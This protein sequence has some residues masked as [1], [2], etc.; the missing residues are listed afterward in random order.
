[1]NSDSPKN[2]QEKVE[3]SLT[4][5]LL[6]ELSH[7]QAAELHEK[8]ARDPELS[9]LY[10]RL[11]ETI[12]VVRETMHSPDEQVAEASEPLKLSEEKRQ[13]LF[14]HFKTV[15]PKEFA[16]PKRKPGMQR[17]EMAI[18]AA[19]VGLIGISGMYV[20]NQSQYSFR[21]EHGS[22]AT[23]TDMASAKYA[24]DASL[25][26]STEAS[27]ETREPRVATTP[28]SG[29]QQP[30]G[31][32]TF[33]F[34]NRTRSVTAHSGGSNVVLP[35]ANWNF[36]TGIEAKR[37]TDPT[38]GEVHGETAWQT[39]T[40][41]A[42]F[43][44]NGQVAPGLNSGGAAGN[45]A[46][47]NNLSDG[48]SNVYG[49]NVVGYYD[50]AKSAS[51]GVMI[52]N[53]LA[54]TSSNSIDTSGKSTTLGIS[55]PRGEQAPTSRAGNPEVAANAANSDAS[56]FD[57][58]S[59]AKSPDSPHDDVLRK[60]FS[61]S[62]ALPEVAQDGAVGGEGKAAPVGQAFYYTKSAGGPSS[63]WIRNF[64]VG[65][66][67]EVATT[68]AFGSLKDEQKSP[69]WVDKS[70]EP[71]AGERFYRS[72]TPAAASPVS[73]GLLTNS[74]A[75]N[76]EWAG[77]ANAPKPTQ[78]SNAFVS[79]YAYVTPPPS[80][81]VDPRTN[82]ILTALSSSTISG[83]VDTSGQW[84]PG[85]GGG[86]KTGASG[87]AEGFNYNAVTVAAAET[88]RTPL[89]GDLPAMGSLFRG[90]LGGDREKLGKEFRGEYKSPSEPSAASSTFNSGV[91]MLTNAVGAAPAGSAVAADDLSLGVPE[92]HATFDTFTPGNPPGEEAFRRRYGGPGTN[93]APYTFTKRLSMEATNTSSYDSSS[94]HWLLSQLGTDTDRPAG[95]QINLNY[96]DVNAE[97]KPLTPSAGPL[98]SPS[99]VGRPLDQR[100]P[101]IAPGPGTM[102]Q[103]GRL[104]F[105]LGKYDE[106][107]VK[108]KEALRANPKDQAALYYLSLSD[109]AKSTQS[110][111]IRAATGQ[112]N[113]T[114]VAQDW[115]NPVKRELL[116]VPTPYARASSVEEPRKAGTAIALPSGQAGLGLAQQDVAAKREA[117]QSEETQLAPAAEK[118]VVRRVDTKPLEMA[119]NDA[120]KD[121]EEKERFRQILD[122]KIA[123]EKTDV[124]L[125]KS[126]MVEIADKAIPATKK[127]SS[128]WDRIRGDTSRDYSSSTR[129]KIEGDQSDISGSKERNSSAAYDPYFVQI[130]FELI[131]SKPMLEK[132][133]KDQ[134]LAE[135]WG[136]EKDGKPLS[137]DEAV[138]QLRKHLELKPVANTSLIEIKVRSDD[139]KQAA[140]IANAVA[141]AYQEHR[142]KQR[143]DLTRSSVRT[144]EERFAE[145]EEKVRQ[146][147]S[148]V[149]Y[150]GAAL[151]I[152]NSP[153]VS[154]V[155]PAVVQ[156]DAVPVRP[157]SPPLIPQA[158]VQ[159]AE[160]S[161]ST[162]SLNVSDVAFKLAAASLEKGQMP[163][164]GTMRSEEFINAFDYRDPEPPAG[165]PVAFA[166]ERAQ[167]PFAQ[168]RDLLRFSL[169]TAATGR[170][171]GKPL[172]LVLLLDSSGSME[173][174]DRVQ[175]IHEAL[176]V[177]AG[178]LQ[179]QD[180]L[181]IVT[182]AR[183]PHLWVD[184][185]PGNQATQAVEQV[186]GIT[187]EGG[188]NLEEAMNLAYATALRHYLANGVN[189]VVLLT[190]GAANLGD[191]EPASLKQKV[192]ANRK[193]G[194]A[195]DCFGIG[196]EGFND[197]LLE[198]L[199]RNGDGRYG[200]INTPEEASSEFARQLA[201]AL[202]VAASDVK[203][204]VE[205]NPK[206][207]TA[208]RQIGYAKHQ[209]T[210]EQ[211]RDNTVD[212]AEIAAS[213]AGNALY[214]IE[215]NPKGEG[216]LATVHIRYK[217][218]GTSDY[219]EYDWPV[220]Y[221]GNA[222]SLE[223][224][225]SAMR[226]AATAAAF[227]EWL[228]LSPFAAEVTPDRLLGYL[229]GVPEQY[230]ADSRPK[231]L[232][233]MIRQ[234]KSISGK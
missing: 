115:A 133:V 22:V 210:K 60:P 118:N 108:F 162:F 193:Q 109:D 33:I 183:T 201:G 69:A 188:T 16:E 110:T 88:T 28:D 116:Q 214:T 164:P 51:A 74:V 160:N 92:Q 120:K 94:S 1:M 148:N 151:N 189:R 182:F 27:Q 3:A 155:A 169:K 112:Q 129:I 86:Q 68:D 66:R 197:D 221:A 146:A 144:L 150:L 226:L 128:L 10:D 222:V 71:I 73:L 20:F 192:E 180:K 216:P 135:T 59:R 186:S 102:V 15:A 55:L 132:I 228:G 85:T 124:D 181:S 106:A 38:L 184:G 178:Q 207:V 229:S 223:Q 206:R 119:Y 213:E 84:N 29:K 199:S 62:I 54:V 63:R 81:N 156:P 36:Q 172:N 141:E 107:E 23:Q 232:E 5:L 101:Q 65:G 14:A 123:S 99:E 11:K 220:P 39:K 136:R 224:A 37:G 50:I 78:S 212:A 90:D 126:M 64:T 163:D 208:W 211:F 100:K 134:K 217:L 87:K 113:L 67:D 121:L 95:G 145:Q 190:D 18:A 12:G 165:V 131:Q 171:A 111:K 198:E 32:G 147:Q 152:P 96:V 218:P 80:P 53:Q 219:R 130:E 204:Q 175:I 77:L 2:P 57:S 72:E 13:K 168:N 70:K 41:Y 75:T 31:G 91:F 76:P 233:W 58:T 143:E 6:G 114:E 215:V 46:V 35:D 158:E 185:I 79:S 104:L 89:L 149:N 161:F 225:S 187:P 154:T 179:A 40:D 9:K 173:R 140:N 231:K 138:A 125:P 170:E 49:L 157:A 82:A 21:S 4:S 83:Y 7:E 8:L 137:T 56:I 127:S 194:I 42:G 205:F 142:R 117:L 93:V 174:A 153:A 166:W 45:K 139:P 103:D 34:N 200:F 227:S 202:N 105:E 230:G 25:Q 176:R 43:A 26:R 177:L 97:G 17:H 159:S 48:A 196:W 98:L 122:M 47:G 30:N 24:A 167:Y 203:V 195:L 61:A 52:A 234:A 191:V 44:L 209:L 19:L